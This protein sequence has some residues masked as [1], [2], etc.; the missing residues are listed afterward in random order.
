[1]IKCSPHLNLLNVHDEAWKYVSEYCKTHENVS[2]LDIGGGNGR[3]K[4]ANGTR[5]SF[6]VKYNNLEINGDVNMPE[7]IK[8]DICHC[9]QIS[10]ERYD[11]VFS[12]NVFE[13]LKMPW[14]AAEECIRINKKGGLNVHIFPFSWHYHPTP[15]DCFRFT[16]TGFKVLFENSGKVKELLTGY[17]LKRRRQDTRGGG[18]EGDLDLV[19]VDK[20]GGWLE[21]WLVL[22]VGK[23]TN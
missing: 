1:M 6:N 4:I 19:P 8:G 2:F 10:D 12:H 15:V 21:C 20:L 11:I 7:L 5:K 9:P 3:G 17:D 22:Y 14:L 18:V 23:R 13:H 16:H